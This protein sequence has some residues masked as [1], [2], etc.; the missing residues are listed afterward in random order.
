MR[1]ATTTPGRRTCCA[2]TDE[3]IEA[4]FSARGVNVVWTLDGLKAGTYGTGGSAITNQFFPIM[5]SNDARTD[6]ARP[7]QWRRVHVGVAPI[8]RGDLAV[9]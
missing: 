5:P 3:Q 8:S 4:W 1:S 9:P 2:I 7:D 6:M